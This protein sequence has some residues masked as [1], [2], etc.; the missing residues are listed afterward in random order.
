MK[1]DT[2]FFALFIL[3]ISFIIGKV[4]Y[5]ISE[6]KY[7]SKTGGDYSYDYGICFEKG[8]VK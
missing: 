3:V 7:C 4:G 8:V 5:E 6:S 2:A 1:Q